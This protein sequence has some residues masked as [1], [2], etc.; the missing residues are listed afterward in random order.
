MIKSKKYSGISNDTIDRTVKKITE[1]YPGIKQ[2][3]L[4]KKV[5]EDLYNIHTAYFKNI[6]YKQALKELNNNKSLEVH[7][8]ILRKYD[9]NRLKSLKDGLYEKVF[10]ITGKPRVLLDLACGLN[11]L[12]LPWM[13]LGG[14]AEYYCY[15]LE[16]N[17]I[18]FLNEYFKIIKKN[19]SAELRDVIINP[20]GKKADVA[21]IFKAS[22]CFEWQEPG[23]TMKVLK[24]LNAKF[25]VISLMMRGEYN[26]QGCRNY[27]KKLIGKY[28]KD[29]VEV[30]SAKEYFR[31]IKLK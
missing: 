28:Y 21:F 15:D 18:K 20:P 13:K 11:P 29:S 17:L 2:K 7:E 9:N 16:E 14:S 3:E 31:I 25:V 26:L 22:T 19:Y 8:R 1:Q 6:N 23:N 12:T 27:F 24:D 4:E 30:I 5:R 10:K